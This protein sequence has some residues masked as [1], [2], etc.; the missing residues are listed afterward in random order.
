M[1]IIST[2]KTVT[3]AEIAKLKGT[4]D[5]PTHLPLVSAIEYARQEWRQ[6]LNEMNNIDSDLTDYAI[7]KT[8]AAERRYM[9]LLEQAKK[10]GVNAWPA[11]DEFIP[12]NKI[13]AESGA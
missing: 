4:F 2:L 11:T 1:N 13:C 8:S 3:R 9:A 12:Q 6:A 7:L 10:E 5:H